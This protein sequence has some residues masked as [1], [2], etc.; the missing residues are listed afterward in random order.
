[1]ALRHAHTHRTTTKHTSNKY[2]ESGADVCYGASINQQIGGAERL[3]PERW[4]V[5]LARYKALQCV[6]AQYRAA[7]RRVTG[8]KASV[9]RRE[10]EAYMA[11]HPEVMEWAATA[12][13]KLK[14]FKQRKR[15]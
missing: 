8:V 14:T 10:A 15:H 4:T 9:L 12:V 11:S 5:G 6:R 1:M 7:G 2:A 13:T 3:S